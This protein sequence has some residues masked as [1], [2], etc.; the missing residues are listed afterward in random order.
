[1]T[2]WLYALGRRCALHGRLVIGIWL[3]AAIALLGANQLLPSSNI[4][5]FS[6]TGTDSTT[7][8]TLLNQAFPQTNTD[9]N[10]V[11]LSSPTLNFGEG[12]GK[13]TV[14][15][16]AAELK[17]IPAVS[18]VSTPSDIPSQLSTDGH[19]AIIGVTINGQQLGEES[20][21]ED[22]LTTA[23]NAAGPD[24]QV[25]LGGYLGQ[26]LSR[27][28]THQS[29]RLGLLAALVVLFFTLRRVWAMVLP[30]INAIFAVGIGLA[31]VGLIGRVVFI[32]D[33]APTLGTML[34]LGVGI[35]YALFL[36]TRHRKLLR[37]GYDVPDAIGRTLGTAGAG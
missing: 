20:V 35:D 23:K 28:D 3:L 34:G 10:P 22:V 1:M 15:R 5:T 6:L 14:D 13:A 4:S 37:Q 12:E 30:L 33:V 2:R 32:P 11:V 24:V 8:Q 18:A 7:A 16:V 36:V 21:S 26:Q 25:D 31:I 27:P 9:P 19:T 17:A 29:E